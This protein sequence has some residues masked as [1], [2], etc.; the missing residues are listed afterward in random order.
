[1][2]GIDTKRKAESGKRKILMTLTL[3][4]YLDPDPAGIMEVPVD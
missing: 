2:V 4:R 1:M 3:I